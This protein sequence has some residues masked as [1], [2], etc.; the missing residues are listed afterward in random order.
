MRLG[1]NG[2][3][4][5]RET[6]NPLMTVDFATDGHPIFLEALLEKDVVDEILVVIESARY[7]GT[8][9]L[10]NLNCL[11]IP[12]LH[13]LLP[14]MRPSDVIYWRGG[15]RWWIEPLEKLKDHWHIYYGAGTPR[16]FWPQWDVIL[17]EGK[18]SFT[19]AGKLYIPWN[20][21]INTGLFKFEECDSPFDVMINAS[22]IFDIKQQYKTI[23][24]AL[25]YRKRYGKDL[26][27]VLPGVYRTSV[28][29]KRALQMAKAEKLS[30]LQPGYVGREQLV[31]LYHK[32]KIF[33]HH[34][35]GLNDRCVLEALSCGVALLSISEGS[36]RYPQWIKNVRALAPDSSPDILAQAIHHLLENLPDRKSVANIFIKNNGMETTVDN[37]TKLFDAIKKI[38]KP[39]RAKLIKE[40][41]A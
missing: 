3:V 33:T 1:Y 13:S 24:A 12:S 19:K 27:C 11:V 32:S 10:G 22:K 23:D 30:I 34:A 37:F 35:S 18:A 17:H 29:T 14:L 41:M 6:K 2:N 28:E 40:F 36:H 15:Y 26:S 39:D 4:L 8:M 38:G 9:K 7:P 16:G 5:D 25:A 20:K 31:E 21:P